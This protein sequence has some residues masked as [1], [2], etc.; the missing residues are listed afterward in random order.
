MKK[1]LFIFL[2][3]ISTMIFLSCTPEDETLTKEDIEKL[4]KERD[5]ESVEVDRISDNNL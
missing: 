3:L 4:L 1:V 5:D 2:F